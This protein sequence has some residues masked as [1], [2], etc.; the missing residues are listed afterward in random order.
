MNKVYDI[1]S[2][3]R[4]FVNNERGEIL[5]RLDGHSGQVGTVVRAN[6]KLYYLF[7]KKRWFET[8]SKFYPKY[9]CVGTG[10][11]MKHI[12]LADKTDGILVIFMINTEYRILGKLVKKF[13]EENETKRFYDKDNELI[14]NIPA[15][16]LERNM[17]V[18]KRID[19]KFE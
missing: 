6:K 13:V 18:K 14:G 19:P 11:S 10:L 3:T 7:Y 5:Y 8:F 17:I 2:L 4:M 16:F 1:K 9:N 12:D 15:T